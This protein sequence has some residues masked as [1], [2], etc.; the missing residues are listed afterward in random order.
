MNKQKL[1]NELNQFY[2]TQKYY[3]H[4]NLLLT[5][6]VYFLANEADCFW[7]MDIIFSYTSNFKEE[8]FITCQLTVKNSKG[9]VVFDDGN[10]NKLLSQKIS[11]TDF[12][13]D[14]IKL[15]ITKYESQFVVMLP[16]EY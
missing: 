4:F 12:P 8:D 6:G 7:L 5:E 10:N 13:L 1:L 2:G 11:Y 3:R 15:Y 14:K 9:K 16:G